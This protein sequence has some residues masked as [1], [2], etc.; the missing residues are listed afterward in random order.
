LAELAREFAAVAPGVVRDGAAPALASQCAS[1]HGWNGDTS[2]VTAAGQ[3][4]R[5]VLRFNSG[6]GE[7]A[8]FGGELP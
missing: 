1:L 4:E 6:V 5:G 7:A 2:A 3:R 8:D